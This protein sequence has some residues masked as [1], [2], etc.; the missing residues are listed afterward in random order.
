MLI[1]TLLAV[2]LVLSRD[3]RPVSPQ[4]VVYAIE[5]SQTPSPRAG[6]WEYSDGQY[7]ALGYVLS[8]DTATHP[9]KPNP[10]AG[11]NKPSWAR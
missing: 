10:F 7:Q 6:S 9:P 11:G 2:S 5:Q 1:G 4:V 3:V 8:S